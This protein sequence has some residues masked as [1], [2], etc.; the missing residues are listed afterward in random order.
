VTPLSPYYAIS[1]QRFTFPDRHSEVQYL[2]N[3][4]R[5]TNIHSDVIW[6]ASYQSTFLFKAIT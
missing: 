1:G 4:G 5:Y 2:I 3:L 6:S